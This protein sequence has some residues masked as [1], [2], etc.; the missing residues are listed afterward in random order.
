MAKVKLPL[1]QREQTPQPPDGSYTATLSGAR[2]VQ[3]NFILI[4]SYPCGV[5]MLLNE[6]AVVEALRVAMRPTH[7]CRRSSQCSGAPLLSLPDE[8]S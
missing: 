1:L 5:E 6:I 7:L 4:G 3:Y 2:R 8:L